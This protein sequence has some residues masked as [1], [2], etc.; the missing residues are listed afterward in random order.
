MITN[1]SKTLLTLLSKLIYGGDISRKSVSLVQSVQG[2]ILISLYQTTLGLAVKIHNRFE[3]KE[4]IVLLN[5]YG[6][7]T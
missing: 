7:I 5:D 2:L 3:S 1:T 4:I 6:Y